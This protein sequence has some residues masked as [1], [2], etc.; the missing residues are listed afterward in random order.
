[1]TW[2]VKMEAVNGKSMGASRYTEPVQCAQHTYA[3]IKRRGVACHVTCHLAS[4]NNDE[5]GGAKSDPKGGEKLDL[6]V[7]SFA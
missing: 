1:M 7:A 4:G 5:G 3:L 6:G 2:A